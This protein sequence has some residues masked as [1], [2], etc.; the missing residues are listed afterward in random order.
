MNI[1]YKLSFYSS[2]LVDKNTP[3][4]LSIELVNKDESNEEMD[5]TESKEEDMEEKPEVEKNEELD[6]KEEV[7]QKEEAKEERPSDEDL[8]RVIKY[9]VAAGCDVNLPVNHFN[10]CKLVLI[11]I[12][13]MMVMMI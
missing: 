9:L 5:V 2:A 7:E 11:A 1:S 13:E 3:T 12:C 6:E 8:L 10:L 4:K